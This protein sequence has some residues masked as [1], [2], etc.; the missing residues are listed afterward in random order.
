M[1]Q[2]SLESKSKNGIFTTTITITIKI[3]IIIIN[4]IITIRSK[5][6][7]FNIG[8]FYQLYNP[9][10]GEKFNKSDIKKRDY[11]EDFGDGDGDDEPFE[12]PN[13]ILEKVVICPAEGGINETQE[14]HTCIELLLLAG[15]SITEYAKRYC[16]FDMGCFNEI[17]PKTVGDFHLK[18]CDVDPKERKEKWIENNIAQTIIDN[19][20]D[21]TFVHN[22]FKDTCCTTWDEEKEKKYKEEELFAHDVVN[23]K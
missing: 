13:T 4:T 22:L 19:N 3:I 7:D 23:K 6:I 10:T 2:Q 9:S 18:L 5:L 14:L 15:A 12:Y 16:G 11:D 8:D 20:C 17:Y 21:A 1:N